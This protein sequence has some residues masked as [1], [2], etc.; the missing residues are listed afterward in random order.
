MP[1][2]EVQIVDPEPG[3]LLVEEGDVGVSPS[4]G[5]EQSKCQVDVKVIGNVVFVDYTV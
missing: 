2:A 1:E 5:G 3:T 4:W